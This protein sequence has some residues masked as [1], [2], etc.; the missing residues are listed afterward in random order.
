MLNN[1]QLKTPFRCLLLVQCQRLMN[2]FENKTA[3]PFIPIK[4]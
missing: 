4:T 3:L 1:R 2:F